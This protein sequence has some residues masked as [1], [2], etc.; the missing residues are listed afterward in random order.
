MWICVHGEVVW[1]GRGQGKRVC[2][3]E[4]LGVWDGEEEGFDLR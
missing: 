1:M 3:P 2:F 4:F